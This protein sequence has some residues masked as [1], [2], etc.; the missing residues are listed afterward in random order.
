MNRSS[1]KH[2]TKHTT[3]FSATCLAMGVMVS[4]LSMPVA[5]NSAGLL[6]YALLWL[7]PVAALL[8]F[9]TVSRYYTV[10]SSQ[11]ESRLKPDGS[12]FQTV[13]AVL[14]VVA[15]LFFCLAASTLILGAAGYV[16]NEVFVRWFPN[17]FFSLCLLVFILAVNL[18]GSRVSR[19]LQIISIVLF[20]GAVLLLSV[21]GLF[22]IDRPLFG[23]A[24]IPGILSFE[25]RPAFMLFWIFM[26][27][28]LAMY[29]EKQ[30]ETLQPDS[31]FLIATFVA[32]FALFWLWS[33]VS[34]AAAPPHILAEST[35]PQNVAAHF[36]A[37]DTGR[38]IMGV[39]LL[40]GSFAGVNLLLL[41]TGSVLSALVSPAAGQWRQEERA[42]PRKRFVGA[43]SLIILAMLLGGMA[44]KEITF[45]VKRA[46]FYLWLITYAGLNLELLRHRASSGIT[47]F[48]A[49]SIGASVIYIIAF[50][51]L[52]ATDQQ[53]KEVIFFSG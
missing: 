46:A 22:T 23:N 49:S 31:Y 25:A 16:F 9:F 32:V 11:P 34:I 17:L 19:Y 18:A 8:N 51:V 12:R 7:L 1:L 5:G 10:L 42:Y 39:A 33:I 30:N 3:F 37:G 20:S 44:G 2:T 4:P 15:F 27:A 28:E 43:L 47:V 6:G 14:Q 29:H 13:I 24:D 26:A 40:A 38:R 41:G 36:I 45:T 48:E 35:G 50:I 52:A 53:L 21:I